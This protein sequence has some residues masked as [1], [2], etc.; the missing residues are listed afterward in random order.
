MFKNLKQNH[1]YIIFNKYY[2]IEN[3]IISQYKLTVLVV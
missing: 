1:P 2:V 3:I